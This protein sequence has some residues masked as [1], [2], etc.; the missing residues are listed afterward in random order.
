MR[1]F[2]LPPERAILSVG[3]SNR[4][5]GEQVQS[6]QISGLAKIIV[7]FRHNDLDLHKAND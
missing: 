6:E 2:P 7:S 5:A 4:A 1:G 3:L